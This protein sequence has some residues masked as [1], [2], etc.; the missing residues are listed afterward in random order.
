MIFRIDPEKFWHRFPKDR[1]LL[2]KIAR[3]F[4]IPQYNDSAFTWQSWKR[5]KGRLQRKAP[6]RWFLSETVPTWWNKKVNARYHSV[7]NWF[8]YRVKTRYHVVEMEVEPGYMDADRRMIHAS[9]QLLKDYVEIEL[10]AMHHNAEEPD[11]TSAKSFY[12]RLAKVR[13]K[14]KRDPE[15]G[16]AY[17]DWSIDDSPGVGIKMA[18]GFSQDET[19]KEK[20]FLYLW[21]TKYR[22]SRIDLYKDDLIWSGPGYDPNKEIFD[23]DCRWQYHLLSELEKFYEAEDEEMLHR[24]IGIRTRLWS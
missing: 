4:L 3:R 19:A 13:R 7:K 2:E 15:A 9:F 10:A 1:T 22:P 17:L 20:K 23:Q 5:Y 14:Q 8:H 6:F 24:L 16:L 12:E 18:G 21:W 11:N